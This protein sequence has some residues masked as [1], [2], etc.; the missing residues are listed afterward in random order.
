M[1]RSLSP[2]V[3]SAA[4]TSS[5][6]SFSGGTPCAKR[7]T[8]ERSTAPSALVLLPTMSLVIMP[9]TFQ[10]FA[11][12]ARAQPVDPYSPCSSPATA[13]NTSVAS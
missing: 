11:F 8:R 9:A 1:G 10:P 3:A 5:G 7:R 2:P 13:M 12:A 6:S 4:R